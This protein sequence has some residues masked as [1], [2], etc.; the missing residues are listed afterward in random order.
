MT[1]HSSGRMIGRALGALTVALLFV[2]IG[3]WSSPSQARPFQQRLMGWLDEPGTKLVAVEFYSDYCEPCKEAAPKWERLRRKYRKDGLKLIVINID[4]HDSALQCKKLPW[5]PDV[6]MC[7]PEMARELGVTSVPQAFLWSWQGNVLAEGEVHVDAVAKAVAAYLADTPRVI[8]EAVDDKGEADLRLRRSVE[9]ELGR[10]KKVTVVTSQKERVALRELAKKS[11][12]V[13]ARD[14]QR[15]PQGAEVSPNM[16]LLVERFPGNISMSLQSIGSGTC[17]VVVSAE[18]EGDAPDAGVQKA[19]YELMTKLKHRPPMMPSR[20]GKAAPLVQSSRDGGMGTLRLETDQD[21][22]SYSVEG[23][24]ERGTL[25]ANEKKLIKLPFRP[26][27]YRVLFKK[28]G[29]LREEVEVLLDESKPVQ[30]IKVAMLREL[31]EQQEQ[32]KRGFLMVK[33]TPENAMV[34]ID[35]VQQA[36]RTPAS[37]DVSAGVHAVRIRRDQHLDWTGEVTVPADD[38]EELTATLTP[39]FAS[40]SVNVTPREAQIFLD[41]KAIASGSHRFEGL[42]SGGYALRLEAPLYRT[43]EKDVF[44]EPGKDV[45]INESL[46]PQFGALELSISTSIGG[47]EGASP[48]V[49]IDGKRQTLE[50]KRSAGD[51]GG[52]IFTGRIEQ[53]PSGERNIEV[54]LRRF[55]PHEAS[56]MVRDGETSKLEAGLDARFGILDITSEPPGLVVRVN[57]DVVGQTPLRHHDEMGTH[58]IEVVGKHYHRPFKKNVLL[59]EQTTERV[60]A[61]MQE[62]LGTLMVASNPPDAEILL[63][64]EPV[65]RAPVSV[66]SVRIGSHRVEARVKGYTPTVVELEVR[67]EKRTREIITLLRLGAIEVRCLAPPEDSKAVRI[68]LG[69]ESA[70][71]ARHRFVE[72]EEGSYEARCHSPRGHSASKPVYARPGEERIVEIDLTNPQLLVDAYRSERSGY[73]IAG[74]TLLGGA[75]A[76]GTLGAVMWSM[77]AEEEA[78]LEAA[79]VDFET[80]TGSKAEAALR[81]E[82]ADRARGL[83]HTTAIASFIV[84]GLALA[85]SIVSLVLS[86]PPPAEIEHL[87]EGFHWRSLRLGA[88]PT[89]RGEGMIL[90]LD[91]RF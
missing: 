91:G 22:T 49:F 16:R 50:L 75:V 23:S 25:N 1:S 82:Q 32:D 63:D 43:L 61:Q 90:T 29:F 62:R 4:D 88:A 31:V 27:P 83:F 72:K 79:L 89:F 15:C 20:S 12:A 87:V 41:G 9:S 47:D 73:Q 45:R 24:E 33:S 51:R 42:P 74:W 54:Q 17:E 10:D 2:S 76:T 64:G 52:N 81:L 55:K 19:V 71:S 37:F 6:Q 13:S 69:G 85:G 5:K 26:L 59:R 65:G 58:T 38:G 53:V 35:G 30:R 78:K 70:A 3:G 68:T 48:E 77:I 18:T 11:N 39:D 56:V 34:W 66:K 57:G 28:M 86:P 7:K 21:G 60:D 36:E 46:A 84:S 8:V 44:I 14:D 67:E 40:L 80:A